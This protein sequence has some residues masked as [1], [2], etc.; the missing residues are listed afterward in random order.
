MTRAIHGNITIGNGFL[1]VSFVNLLL[2]IM[3]TSHDTTTMTK[4]T[5]TGIVLV[6]AAVT[7]I[8]RCHYQNQQPYNHD[9]KLHKCHEDTNPWPKRQQQQQ[10]W[11]ALP[12][13]SMTLLPPIPLRMKNQST[14][15]YNNLSNRFPTDCVAL[16]EIASLRHPTVVSKSTRL[17]QRFSPR[18]PEFMKLTI[19][20][21]LYMTSKDIPW[22][23]FIV[24]AIAQMPWS[25]YN[26]L[27]TGNPLDMT[28]FFDSQI[29]SMATLTM[30]FLSKCIPKF[31]WWEFWRI[32][33][34]WTTASSSDLLL[35]L[36][37][38]Q[39]PSKK[40]NAM[41]NH[42]QIPLWLLQSG[43][44]WFDGVMRRGTQKWVQK[45]FETTVEVSMAPKFWR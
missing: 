42:D 37:R 30:Q 19:I 41:S 10:H 40:P 33:W 14:W 23:S 4:T 34:K 3:T 13:T 29:Q 26:L 35:F 38:K 9:T 18:I 31:L 17:Q 45:W 24:V 12:T 28:T 25:W 32:F 6:E 20:L 11:S 1:I 39:Y 5:K 27:P 16:D 2:W 43:W 36:S 7:T 15:I 44:E 22:L 8:R 21:F